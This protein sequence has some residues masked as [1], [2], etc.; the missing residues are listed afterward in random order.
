MPALQETIS[1]SENREYTVTRLNRNNLADVAKLHAEVYGTAVADDYF[2]NKYNTA[3]TGVENAGF[4]AYNP[5]NKPV[6]YYG[7]IPCFIEYENKVMLAAQSAD[8]MT[9]PLH[10]YKGMFVEL[11]NKTF[12]LCRELGIRLIFGFPNH[13]SYHGAVN[14]LG[15]KMTET[16]A[17][18]IIR[19]KSLP[20]ESLSKKSGLLKKAY[21]QYSQFIMKRN[22]LPLQGI[23]NSVIADGFAGVYRSVDYFSYKTYS[24]SVVIG[25]ENAKI[26]ISTKYGLVIGDMEGVHK[27]NFTSL[28]NMLKGIAKR[29][30]LREIQFHCSPGTGLHDFFAAKYKA[31]P[32]YPVLFQDFGSVIPPEKIK[33]TFADIDIF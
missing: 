22:L 1:N 10:R 5:D 18:F 30:G 27:M 33:F 20:F 8:T 12:D 32:S 15:W 25:M 11:S 16:M 31:T 7:V 2:P 29:L 6:A 19:V 26:W 9:H 23:T 14:K 17:C 4:I 13:N 21:K 3:Y 28:I 24:P